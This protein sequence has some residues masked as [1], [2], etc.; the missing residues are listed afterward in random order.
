MRLENKVSLITGAGRGLGQAIALAFAREGSDIVI[1]DINLPEAE[2]TA[3]EVEALERRSLAIKADV[4]NKAE[5]EEMVKNVI[6]EFG[7]ID[8]LVNNAGISIVGAS[9]ELEESR[10]RRG[11]D[12]LLTGVF[13]CSQVV[14][15]EMIK[16]NNGKIINIA[17][18][19]GLGGFPER[20][21]YCSAKA[22]VI[23]LTKVLASE[24]A[25]HNIHVNAIAPGSIKTSMVE[26]LIK[27]GFY[28]EKALTSRIPLGRLGTPEDIADVAVFLASDEARYITGQTIVADGGWNAYSYLQSWLDEVSQ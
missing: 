26:D 5:V 27:K 3:G 23:S 17:S 12:I 7:K 16:Q 8:I 4:S 19:A 20:A 24:W 1:N 21:C 2:K 15:K 28:A 10:W 9:A 25:R 11:L 13:F 18:L 6:Q 22:G 14:G